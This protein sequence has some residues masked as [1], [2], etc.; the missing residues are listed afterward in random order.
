MPPVPPA[1]WA[2]GD[3]SALS[4]PSPLPSPPQGEVYSM[5]KD[6][7]HLSFLPLAH[8]ME[9]TIQVRGWGHSLGM[10]L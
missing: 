10:S 9:R 6:D 2:M 8:S 5:N 1:E 3:T 7:V 4:F